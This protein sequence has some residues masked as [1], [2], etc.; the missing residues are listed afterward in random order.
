[1]PLHA[2][3]LMSITAA[4]GA[5]QAAKQG[6]PWQIALLI[7]VAVVVVSILGGN[8]AAKR[9]RMPDFGWKIGLLFFTILAPSTILV[10]G[11]PPK[12]GIDLKGGVIL[13][14]EVDQSKKSSKEPLSAQ[15]MEQLV[16]AIS[17]RINPGGQKELTIRQSGVDQL[18][19][20]I[21]DVDE[22]EA[23]RLEDVISQQGTLE[24]RILANRKDHRRLIERAEG[25][26]TKRITDSEGNVL[27]WWVPIAAGR[28]NEIPYAN[29]EIARRVVK[30]DDRE[31]TEILVAGDNYNVTGDYL[32]RA[33]PG[34]DHK[35]GRPAVDFWFDS[36]GATLFSG[37]TSDNLP[38]KVQKGFTRKLGIILNGEL[39]SAPSIQS[40][41][42]NQGQI[43]GSFTQK[44]VKSLVDVLNAGALPAAL[45][46]EPVSRLMTGP[47]LGKDTI[48]K[49]SWSIFWSTLLV[50]AFMVVYYRFSGLVACFALVMNLILI[51]AIMIVIKAAFTLPGLAGLVLTVGMAVDANVLIYE[52]FRE[53]FARGAALRMVIRNGFDRATSAIVDSNLTTLITAAVLWAVGTEQIKGFAVTL[54][55]GVAMSMYTAVFCAHVIFDI[56]EKRRWITKLNMMQMIGATNVDFLAW[57]NIAVGA[58]TVLIVVG[59]I[60]ATVRGKGLLNIDFTGGVS[61]LVQFD[62]NKPQRI[63]EIRD[64]LTG[65]PDLVVS[66]V[67]IR[68]EKENIAF[69][70]NTSEAGF[71]PS[72]KHDAFMSVLRQQ[73]ESTYGPEA[74][75]GPRQAAFEKIGDQLDAML[76]TERKTDERKTATAEI[77]KQIDAIF[78]EA[79]DADAREAALG[80]VRTRLRNVQE[81]SIQ[82]V[83]DKVWEAF[84]PDLAANAFTI[85]NLEEIAPAAKPAAPA[86]KPATEKPAPEKPTPEKPAVAEP[87]AEKPPA[88]KPAPNQPAA[89]EP[90][91]E[92]PAAEKPTVETPGAEK[93]GMAAP[94]AAP[95][96]EKAAPQEPSPEKPASDNPTSEEPSP[97]K[98]SSEKPATEK[99]KEGETREPAKPKAADQGRRRDLPADSVLAL[100]GTDDTATWLAQADAAAPQP[101]VPEDA[102]VEAM[103]G[104]EH[105]ASPQEPAG[106]APAPATPAETGK[107]PSEGQAQAATAVED[108]LVGGT[109]ADL[110]FNQPISHGALLDLFHEHFGGKKNTPSLQLANPSFEEGSDK[111]FKNWEVK[112]KL[113]PAEAEQAIKAVQHVVETTPYFPSS[114][115]IGGTV[116]ESTRTLAIVAIVASLVG[117]IAYLWFRFQRIAYGL[118]ATIAVIHDVAATL[119]VMA[120]SYWIAE[121]PGMQSILLIDPFK[122]SLSVLAAYL[123]IIGYSLNDTIVIFDRIREIKG[124][125]PNVTPEMVNLSV[126]QTLSRTLLTSGTVLI[127]VVVL[128]FG[129]GETIHAFAFALLFGTIVGSYSTIY[130]A[131][132][133]LLW[134]SPRPETDRSL[135]SPASSRPGM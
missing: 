10:F 88:E 131:S 52:R 132:P 134:L 31:V 80:A 126:N 85:T 133:I 62:E 102:N 92:K 103:P 47:Q 2:L 81:T 66:N 113:P 59:L 119:G 100:A 16:A 107:A 1:M 128:Y 90:I 19:V 15:Q 93:P 110:T 49:G 22:Q 95:S 63:S 69:V 112:I 74:L 109:R 120:L 9:L 73:L 89:E 29:S 7:A 20:I 82:I 34:I 4:A 12:L 55:L 53:E 28:E 117:V 8:Y 11:W 33:A 101:A 30:I 116:A 98:R 99:S 25:E 61:V 13:I 79:P 76:A 71:E 105:D 51:V 36:T 18:E 37:L 3:S 78:A 124:K 57:R 48:I 54:F 94:K 42:S 122:I 123:T 60:G 68:G 6:L 67:H 23:K 24:F 86:A 118:A 39:Y 104:G 44:E 130:I 70:V 106:T 108:A 114:N 17:K 58:S 121:L 125:L 45:A 127:V 14:Y 87:A 35:T 75:T 129:G 83:E 135:P 115:T 96:P 97:E 21:P 72:Q 50:V 32:Q 40:T 38:D 46:R 77:N 56:A 84:G 64:K 27:A 91:P 26:K 41:I 111:P 5:G 65:L 43:T